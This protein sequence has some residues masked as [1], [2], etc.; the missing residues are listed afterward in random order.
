MFGIIPQVKL[1]ISL[2]NLIGSLVEYL[3]NL[4]RIF[5]FHF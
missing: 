5:I 3:A 4:D 1:K 2:L